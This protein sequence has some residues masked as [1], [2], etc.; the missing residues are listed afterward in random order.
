MPSRLACAEPRVWIK[1][2]SWGFQAVALID[3]LIYHASSISIEGDSYRKREAE[4]RATPR[5]K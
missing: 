3:R 1:L 5:G 2:R 4:A